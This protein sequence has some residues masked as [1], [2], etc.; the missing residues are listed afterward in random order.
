MSSPFRYFTDRAD[1]SFLQ[2][3]LS[4]PDLCR[5]VRAPGA[6][7]R[8]ISAD[9]ARTRSDGVRYHLSTPTK[10]TTILLSIDLRCWDQLVHYGAHDIMKREYGDWISPE[11]EPDYV[12]SLVFET[13]RVPT[14][15]GAL[16]AASFAG[17]PC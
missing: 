11:V 9:R 10:K 14:D 8:Q 2:A 4:R 3:W 6:S 16:G 13:D 5:L 12:F 1:A 15:P 17:V 7:S